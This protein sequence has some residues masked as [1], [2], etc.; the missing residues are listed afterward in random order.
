[1]ESVKLSSEDKWIGAEARVALNNK[2]Q[3][4]YHLQDVCKHTFISSSIFKE[5]ILSISIIIS[6]NFLKNVGW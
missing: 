2:W 3:L 6:E 1:M 5:I 4:L